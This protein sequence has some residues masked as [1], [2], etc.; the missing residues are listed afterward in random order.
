VEPGAGERMVDNAVI[1]V[2][3]MLGQLSDLPDDLKRD[4]FK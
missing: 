3:E 4:V 1:K 2:H